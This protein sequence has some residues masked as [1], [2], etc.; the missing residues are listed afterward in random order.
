MSGPYKGHRDSSRY[1]SRIVRG[2]LTSVDNING[3]AQVNTLEVYSVRDVTVPPLW[4]SSKGRQTAWGRYMPFGGENVHVGYRNDDTPVIVGYDINAPGEQIQEG[5]PQLRKFQQE[6]KVGYANFRELKPGEFDYKSSGDAYIHGS[7]QGTLFL[8]GGQAFIKLDKQA[9]R[10]EYKAAEHHVISDTTESRFGT[11]YRKAV[12]SDATETP[13]SQGVFKE[14]MVDVNFPLPSGT[15]SVQSRA[16]LHMGD[17]LDATN[18]PEL[19][20]LGAPL[21]YRL[22]LG[23]GGDI[24]EVFSTLVDNLGN[25]FIKQTQPGSTAEWQTDQT[26]VSINGP[27]GQ[28]Y[29]ALTGTP[30]VKVAI[31]D[32]LELLYNQL[33]A[34]LDA[35]DAHI[36]PTGMGPSGVPAPLIVCP[37]WDA[38][39]GS[40]KLNIPD[41]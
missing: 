31:A 27:L 2:Q 10:A 26:K 33:K 39:I 40:T 15:K 7:N 34:K 22:S 29:I 28:F 17:I 20:P 30:S 24:L 18:I 23:D 35:F 16:K 3:K 37:P 12:P 6:N 14:Y 5:H 4:F 36:H 21:R 11:V 13:S 9:Y 41:L 32:R 8:A 19:G 1:L 38:T 25:Y